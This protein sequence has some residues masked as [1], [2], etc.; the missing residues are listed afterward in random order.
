MLRRIRHHV[1][2]LHE[3]LELLALYGLI[4]F[5]AGMGLNYAITNLE[6]SYTIA[7]TDI[8]IDEEAAALDYGEAPE[9]EQALN[10][11][12]LGEDNIRYVETI[13]NEELHSGIKPDE[14]DYAYEAV[15]VPGDTFSNLL[16][17]SGIDHAEAHSISRSMSKIYDL[18]R[19][20]IGQ[21]I[22]INF[23]EQK[24]S[25]GETVARFSSLKIQDATE[26]FIVRKEGEK[27]YVADKGE[28]LLDKQ[29]I[30]AKGIVLHS[31]EQLAR[32]LQIPPNI[33][34]EAVRAYS[35][36]VDFQRDIRRGSRFEVIYEAFFDEEG[37][38]VHDGGLLYA[39]LGVRGDDIRIY[40]YMG[41]GDR[42]DYYKSD[43]RSIRR[44]LLKTPIDGARISSTYGLRKHPVLKYNRMH[45]GVDF[46]APIGTP[47]YAA[48]DGVVDFAGKL[49][50][51]GNYIRIRHNNEYSTAYAHAS[52]F[53]KGMRKGRRVKQGEVIAYVGTTGMSTGPHLHYEVLRKGA[54][55]N[56]SK[57]KT[58]PGKKLAGA[59][60]K[61]FEARKE[62]MHAMINRLTKSKAVAEK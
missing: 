44:S 30:T 3:K 38:K 14:G 36:D 25:N 35:Y 7:S 28:R 1:F 57:V 43:G 6:D 27:N 10:L 42:V 4:M 60:L 59:E 31:I 24:Q 52:R 41:D 33:M 21:K 51:Y 26:N 23:E 19:L 12:V 40:Q 16:V 39:S 32:A 8:T 5:F 37:N 54:Q 20:K 48:G 58:R 45:K 17:K 15:V 11:Q 49:R 13:R 53:A 22:I 18:R 50:G 62:E 56:P 61:E 47:F 55:V 9:A 46:A 2:T 29:I 34:A